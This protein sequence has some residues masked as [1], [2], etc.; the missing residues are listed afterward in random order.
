MYLSI[1][2]VCLLVLALLEEF[3]LL[4]VLFPLFRFSYRSGGKHAA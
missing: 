2:E 4:F 1:S 3:Y